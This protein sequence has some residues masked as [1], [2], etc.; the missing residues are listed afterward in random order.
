MH[1]PYEVADV[2]NR[3]WESIEK[4]EVKL[5]SWQVRTLRAIKDCRTSALGGHIDSCTSCGHLQLSYNSCRNR[6]CPKC[7]GHKKEE[8]IKAREEDLLPA[9]YFHVVFTLPQIINSVAITHPRLIYNLLFKAAWATIQEFGLDTKWLGGKVGM[10]SILHTWGQNMSLHPHLHCIVPGV[11]VDEKGYYKRVKAK[12][13]ILFPVRAMSK[14]FRGKYC[15][16]L[17][18]KL[19]DEYQKIQQELYK[20]QWVVYAKQPFGGSEQVIEYLGR[21]THKIAISN[22]RI[23]S[24]KEDKVTF[25]YKDYR[26]AGKP[27]A[28]TL[29]NEEFIRRFSLHILP[30]GFVRIRH[31][32]ILSSTWKR[33]KLQEIQRKMTTNSSQTQSTS[34]DKV[35]PNSQ[36]GQCPCCKQYS[37]TILCLFDKRGPPDKWL[38]KLK[39]Y[40]LNKVKENNV[41]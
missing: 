9:K 5:N 16:L 8:W 40:Q 33:G 29:V 23:K 2:L 21:Y 30:K 7:Q 3:A 38:K 18:K 20:H 35:A 22:H 24:V 14:M 19:Q 12:S 15:H 27:K 11:A 6:H 26:Q 4:R 41:S 10:V 17:K 13:K 31:Y 34:I 37:L 28:M 39:E 1:S 32:G 25:S 36:Q